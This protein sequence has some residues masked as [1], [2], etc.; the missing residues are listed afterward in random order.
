MCDTQGMIERYAHLWFVQALRVTTVSY[1]KLFRTIY[2]CNQTLLSVPQ[3]ILQCTTIN[4]R[5]LSRTAHLCAL[6]WNTTW[7]KSQ[8]KEYFPKC[9]KQS[10]GTGWAC[11]WAEWVAGATGLPAMQH[12]L[13]MGS[14]GMQPQCTHSCAGLGA[15][16][17]HPPAGRC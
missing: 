17:G 11:H 8:C 12:H 15:W 2:C 9:I 14:M 10:S 7:P 13:S 1:M 6:H 16:H 5:V 3:S 4:T